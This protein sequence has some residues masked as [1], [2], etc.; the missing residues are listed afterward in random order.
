M[1]VT[2]KE[3]LAV[4]KSV[5]Y[6]ILADIV[7]GTFSIGPGNLV[8]VGGD[9]YIPERF[10]SLY[11]RFGEVTGDFRCDGCNITSLEGSPRKVGGLFDCS[12][13]NIT[14]LEG[15]PDKVGG[16]FNCSETRITSLQ[17]APKKIGRE[18]ICCETDIDWG[19][20][21]I[22][23]KGYTIINGG[24]DGGQDGE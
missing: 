6:S 8:N 12:R 15:A 23:E 7:D 18:L 1:K 22:I 10:T 16:L 4:Y 17:F 11:F 5:L 21:S 3:A 13:T 24:Q 19:H 9:V 20:M 2:D 14:S